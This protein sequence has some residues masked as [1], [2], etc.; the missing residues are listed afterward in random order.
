MAGLQERNLREARLR[1]IWSET[2][3]RKHALD[4]SPTS[5]DEREER[6]AAQGLLLLRWPAM[7]THQVVEADAYA[8]PLFLLRCSDHEQRG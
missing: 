1:S 6:Q 5:H 3:S 2:V 8:T 4:L 7:G